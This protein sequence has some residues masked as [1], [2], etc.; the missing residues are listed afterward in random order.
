MCTP[1]KGRGVASPS[2]VDGQPQLGKQEAADLGVR[3]DE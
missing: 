1:W 3:R 2:V